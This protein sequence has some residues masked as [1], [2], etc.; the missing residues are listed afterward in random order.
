MFLLLK[1]LPSWCCHRQ[2][3]EPGAW[4]FASFVSSFI[5]DM[6]WT[7]DQRLPCPEGFSH[8]IGREAVV[9]VWMPWLLRWRRAAPYGRLSGVLIRE[10]ER[11][12]AQGSG[13]WTDTQLDAAFLSPPRPPWTLAPHLTLSPCASSHTPAGLGPSPRGPKSLHCEPGARASAC[14]G[15]PW[16]S[17]SGCRGAWH[18]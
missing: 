14:A 15:R 13:W 2:G 8:A 1:S 3:E 9:R 10:R 18:H 16:S 4:D 5:P 12:L 6:M 7:L 11:A 17:C